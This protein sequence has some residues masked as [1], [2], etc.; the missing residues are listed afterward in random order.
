MT[1]KTIA[2][3]MVLL[4]VVKMG[5]TIEILG[6]EVDKFIPFDYHNYAANK[7]LDSPILR[8]LLYNQ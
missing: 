4:V 7:V 8:S 2:V 1:R 5:V 6:S 3:L